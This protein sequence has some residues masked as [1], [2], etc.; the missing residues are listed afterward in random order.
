[1]LVNNVEEFQLHGNIEIK[2]FL[3][4]GNLLRKSK[5]CQVLLYK[6]SFVLKDLQTAKQFLFNSVTMKEYIPDFIILDIPYNK[7]KHIDFLAWIKE[8]FNNIRI[9]VI[10]N[11]A[12]I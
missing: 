2:S 7:Q 8:R 5:R 4:I 10:Y 6:D 9:P 3:Y 1:M 11:E 12:A